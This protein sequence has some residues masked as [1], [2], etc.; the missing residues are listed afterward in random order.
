MAL[1]LGFRRHAWGRARRALLPTLPLE[2][3]RLRMARARA[4]GLDYATYASVRARAGCDVTAFLFSSNAL[5][6]SPDLPA[7]RAA[8]LAQ[9]AVGRLV[10]VHAPLA[11]EACAARADEAGVPF[12]AQAR[13]PGFTD[14]PRE[15]RLALESLLRAAGLSR[16][17]VVV[18][19]DTAVEREWSP[20]ARLSGYL[21]AERW[22]AA[23]P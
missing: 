10:A 5:R 13:A 23:A 4:V 2:V 9:T 1:G 7:D 20:A 22:M 16:S 3:V 21:P 11:P 14:S 18:V 6:L 8:R 17:G 15:L 19:G 12:A